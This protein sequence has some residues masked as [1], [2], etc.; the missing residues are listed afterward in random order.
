MC[1]SVAVGMGAPLGSTIRSATS[2][3]IPLEISSRFTP[4]NTIEAAEEAQVPVPEEV[5]GPQP[6]SYRP[7]SRRRRFSA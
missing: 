2:A 4:R 6:R 7:L 3:V 5:V 1:G